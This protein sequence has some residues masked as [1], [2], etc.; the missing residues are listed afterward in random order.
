[1]IDPTDRDRLHHSDWSARRVAQMLCDVIA[2]GIV[3]T[4]LAAP[5]A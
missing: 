4:G 2:A 1:M 3:M 5:K